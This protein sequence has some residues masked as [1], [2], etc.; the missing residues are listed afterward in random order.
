MPGRINGL[1]II[2][3]V[4]ETKSPF[5]FSF[6]QGVRIYVNNQS[7]MP[8][9]FQG[10][11][12][13]TGFLTNFVMKRVFS[14]NLPHPYSSCVEDLASYDSI[15]TKYFIEGGQKYSQFDCFLHCYQRTL[16]EKC[17]CY[18]SS[19]Q[20]LTFGKKQCTSIDE[21]LCHMT[22]LKIFFTNMAVQNCSQGLIIKYSF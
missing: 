16:T 9:F 5:S 7:V 19:F 2:V 3:Y 18:D 22:L 14:H 17:G 11:D 10:Y 20:S 8:N 21:F 12:A 15:F 4:G 13:S 6:N 1:M